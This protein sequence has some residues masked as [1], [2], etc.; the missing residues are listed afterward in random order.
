M[1]KRQD[2]GGGIEI[3]NQ[4]TVTLRR[5]YVRNNDSNVGGGV[6][7]STGTT[8]N[9]EIDS[10]V[11]LNNALAGDGGGIY[12]SGGV[13]NVSGD[14]YIGFLFFSAYPNTATNNGGGLYLD[15]CSAYLTS[16]AS[17]Y[18]V[19][20]ANTAANG[21]GIYA[22]KNSYINLLGSHAVVA[23]NNAG[24]GGG[25]YL[26][27]GA[28]LYADNGS[29]SNNTATGFGGG[30]Y[31]TG[32]GTLV[33]MDLNS[34]QACSG[35]CTRLSANTATNYGGAAFLT[36]G[37]DLDLYSVYVEENSGSLGS[38]IYAR[39]DAYVNL[40]NVMAT[41]NIATSNYALRLFNSGGTPTSTVSN[42]TFA[43]NSGQTA[44][45]GIDAGVRLDGDTL[46]LWGNSGSSLVAESGDVTIDC[47]IVQFDFPGSNN[48]ISDPDFWDA[49]NGDYHLARTS[50]AIDLC[51]YGQSRDVD[52][53][54][55]PYDVAGI[56][57]LMEAAARVTSAQ[58]QAAARH[59][60][61]VTY[62]ELAGRRLEE[63]LGS[64]LV[65]RDYDAFAWL[66]LSDEEFAQLQASGLPFEIEEGFGLIS[67]D[68]WRFDPQRD[69]APAMP[70]GLD[71][72]P[73][74]DLGQSL[75]L[76][77]LYAPANDQDM[78]ALSAAGT[79]LQHYPYNAF[80]LWSDARRLARLNGN[81]VSYTHLRAHETVL[82]L[83]CRLLL[84][85][86][87]QTTYNHNNFVYT[88]TIQTTTKVPQQSHYNDY[89]SSN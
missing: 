34:G 50:P 64:A 21:G 77:Q 78:E 27:S 1:Y 33:D 11:Y 55:R 43:G 8:L 65:V 5:T 3:D 69:G 88:K 71:G 44:T 57:H 84:E 79:V 80:L 16:T 2:F 85:K 46:I 89:R 37:A 52:W 20:V 29:I 15:N 81:P 53:Y 48:L 68:A 36:S 10:F 49:A 61:R 17:N 13:V 35:K 39:G 73:R 31:A 62:D 66:A 19:I 74:N 70:A 86:K 51:S 18:A 14:S 83:V 42:S 30:V 87:K 41:D 24:S 76:V 6:H 47:S 56:G 32:D 12:C 60:V 67:F 75:S 23:Y 45:F 54:Q 40:Y 9:L 82:D 72:T 59:A 38:A 25:L 7:M 63:A 22:L 28:D 26:T 58:R 4:N